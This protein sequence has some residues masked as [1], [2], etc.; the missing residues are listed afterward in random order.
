MAQSSTAVNSLS[1]SPLP[2][3]TAA[4]Y[5]FISVAVAAGL[6]TALLGLLTTST[7][8]SHVVYLH[9]IQMTWC[10]DLDVPE[11]FGFLKNQVTPFS[12][13]TSDGEHLYAWHILPRELYRKNERPLVAE[14]TGFVS[15]ITSRLAFQ[16]LRD[17]PDARL[18]IH[19]HGAGG[20]VGSGYRV[21]NYHA[22]SAGQPGKIHVLTF[23]YRGFGRSTGTRSE[24]GLILDALAVADWAMNVAS[25]PSCRILIF[26]QSMGTAVSIAVSKHLALQHPPVVFAGTI[27]VAPFVDVATLVATYR[28]AGTIPVLAP[29]AKLPL[30]FNY[31]QRFIQ[32]KWLSKDNIA[33][34]VRANEVNGEMYRLTIIHAE[35][36]YDIP[37]HHTPTIFWHV[38]NA[39]VYSGISCDELEA[40]KLESKVDLGAAG[41]VMEWRAENGV[42]REEILKTGL[43][44]VIMGYPVI[45]MAVM[46]SFE[47]VDPSF[48]G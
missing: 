15:D 42:I 31:L 2:I 30:L 34:Y 20:T 8:Q 25:I 40:R 37:C 10:K 36:D 1:T 44:D 19:M 11:I 39:S 32:D 14:P 24:S 6:Y 43:H 12:I 48:T 9:A 26:A 17:N 23:D 7:F 3:M 28:V 13:E 41:S 33:Q 21:P 46:R 4:K 47:A 29:L 5:A 16:L 45:T 22:L 35:D 27:L 18:I 38:V